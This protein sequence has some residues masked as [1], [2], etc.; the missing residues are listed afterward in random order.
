MYTCSPFSFHRPKNTIYNAASSVYI[1]ARH[2]EHFPYL[3]D[4]LE[5]GLIP[6]MF[7]RNIASLKFICWV[8][9][10]IGLGD[11]IHLK[12]QPPDWYHSKTPSPPRK[13]VDLSMNSQI[14]YFLWPLYPILFE[15]KIPVNN[16][17]WFL[18]IR[19]KRWWTWIA[20]ESFISSCFW[21]EPGITHL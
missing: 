17:G 12:S 16:V 2:W 18:L 6:W 1:L 7:P 19:P 21:T 13:K 14:T 5:I 8:S 10:W 9:C 11:P 15:S 3:L 20:G 4:E